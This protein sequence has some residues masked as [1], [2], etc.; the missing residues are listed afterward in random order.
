MYI[1]YTAFQDDKT[2]YENVRA[3]NKERAYLK[4]MGIPFKEV[5]GIHGKNSGYSLKIDRVYSQF[6]KERA[7]LA[8][9]EYVLINNQEQIFLA[10]KNNQ[11]NLL[12]V[13]NK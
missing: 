9:Q 6:I 2:E 13:Y 8:G 5:F 4:E 3:H 7:W 1:I 10:Y 11:V 12:T